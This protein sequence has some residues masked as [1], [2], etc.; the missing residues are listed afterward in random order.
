MPEAWIQ[1]LCPEC[2]E[3]WEENP[4]DLPAPGERYECPHCGARAPVSEFMR[5]ERDLD[6]LEEFHE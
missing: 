5:T 4:S 3:G 2:G 6:I 1:L